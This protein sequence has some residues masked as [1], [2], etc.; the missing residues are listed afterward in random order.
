MKIKG[1]AFAFLLSASVLQAEPFQLKSPE[2]TKGKLIADEQVFNG[3]G[4][5]GG[6]VSPSLSWSGLPK[7]TKSIAVTVYDPDAPTGSGWW[8]WVVFNLPA[9]TTS[10]PANAGNL[11]KDL[12]PKETIQSRTDFGTGG[13]GG[14]CPP[15]GDKPH[16]YI[17]TV[18][19]LKDKIGADQN[20]S[21]AL[22]GFYINQLKIGEAKLI[23][24]FGR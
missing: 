23:A 11:E 12:L 5:T 9:T 24:K 4:C 2:L 18:Y 6:N 22:I 19:A 13:Y 14:P 16:R 7:D 10:L 15:K 8:H 3:F 21:G 1:I 17:F 20:S